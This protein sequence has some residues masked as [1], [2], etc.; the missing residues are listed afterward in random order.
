MQPNTIKQWSKT[1]YRVYIIITLVDMF[2]GQFSDKYS[3]DYLFSDS[4]LDPDTINIYDTQLNVTVFK[5]TWIVDVVNC[6]NIK[7]ISLGDYIL[8]P[9]DSNTTVTSPKIDWSLKGNII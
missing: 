5:S 1:L 2:G 3:A 8:I 6:Y 7:D 4:Q 9:I